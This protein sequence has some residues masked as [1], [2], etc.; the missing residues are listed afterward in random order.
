M[1]DNPDKT[2]Y[3]LFTPDPAEYNT[4]LHPQIDNTLPMN[5]HQIF[6]VT[7]DPR[8]TY[9]IHIT[10]TTC[11]Q[12]TTHHRC[13]KCKSMWPTIGDAHHYLYGSHTLE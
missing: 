13:T 9:T 5:T 2:T 8:L 10:N 1:F 3:T 6:R 4:K 11:I 7:L 12:I